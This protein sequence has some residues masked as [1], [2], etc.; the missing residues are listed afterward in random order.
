[1]ADQGGQNPDQD[2]NS[3]DQ[4]H[5]IPPNTIPI[6]STTGL[7]Q[8]HPFHRL[9][10]ELILQM[11]DLLPAEAFINFAFAHYPL[12]HRHGLVPSLSTP[13]LS[14]IVSRSR[15]PRLFR[16]LPLPSELLLQTIRH[17]SPLDTMRFVLANYEDLVRSGIAPKLTAET[18]RS[19]RASCWD[20]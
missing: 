3:S 13:E 14:H 11:I 5:S 16:L 10:L 6:T 8:P 19:L 2:A 15:L 12:L 7:T 20:A 1:M 18:V 17:L 9:P 4:T